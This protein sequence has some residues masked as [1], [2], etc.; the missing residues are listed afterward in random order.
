MKRLL[1]GFVVLFVVVGISVLSLPTILHSAGLHIEYHGAT[2]ELL[3][4]P[5]L[6]MAT[7]YGVLIIPG[8]IVAVIL[9]VASRRLP[10][11]TDWPCLS[12]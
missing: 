3:G 2:V 1:K 8:V 9:L 10:N 11:R 6:V 12:P 7:S 4:K 5:A